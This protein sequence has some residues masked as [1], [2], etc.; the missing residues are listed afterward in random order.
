MIKKKSADKE[1]KK[2]VKSV[3]KVRV[4]KKE[5]AASPFFSGWKRVLTAE[6]YRRRKVTAAMTGQTKA[7]KKSK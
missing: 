2:S 4:K 7:K 1:V 5:L 3:E 6:G